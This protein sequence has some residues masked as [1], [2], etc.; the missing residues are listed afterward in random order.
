[1]LTAF[2]KRI[3]LL[4]VTDRGGSENNVVHKKVFL[5]GLITA[6][7]ILHLNLSAA[8][9]GTVHHSYRAFHRFGQAK[10]ANGG[11]VLGSSQFM[12]LPHLPYM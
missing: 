7:N 11:L 6:Y 3:I 9:D 2:H 12:L 1:M 5:I 8:Q 4:S 10:I